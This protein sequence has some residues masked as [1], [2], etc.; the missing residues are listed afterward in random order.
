M[1][2]EYPT[3]VILAEL[4]VS[5]TICNVAIC[6]LYSVGQHDIKNVGEDNFIK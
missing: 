5:S 6:H 2:N 4:Q 1:M 3:A